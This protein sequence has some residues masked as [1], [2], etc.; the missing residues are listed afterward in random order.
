MGRAVGGCQTSRP[1]A[2]LS[3]LA[4]RPTALVAALK[5]RYHVID[6]R[7]KGPRPLD[8]RVGR[9]NHQAFRL[10]LQ[11]LRLQH[12]IGRG[13]RSAPRNQA[14]THAADDQTNHERHND[15]P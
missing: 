10:G 3:A 9:A 4:I 12:L 2:S 6:L 14:A 5:L 13:G 15:R 7:G 1:W 8:R 11:L